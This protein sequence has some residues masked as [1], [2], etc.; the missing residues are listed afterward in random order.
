MISREKYRR[1]SE[2]QSVTSESAVDSH[3]PR[4]SAGVAVTVGT[5]DE[6]SVVGLVGAVVVVVQHANRVTT[7]PAVL[8]VGVGTIV[9]PRFDIALVALGARDVGMVGPL[10]QLLDSVVEH[11]AT[12]Q[13]SLNRHA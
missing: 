8:V 12:F 9:E 4:I 3:L 6:V 10:G 2:N 11:L 1:S 7:F 5:R 13:Y